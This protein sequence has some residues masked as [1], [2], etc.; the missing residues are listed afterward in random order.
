MTHVLRVAVR[1]SVKVSDRMQGCLLHLG[2]ISEA[3]QTHRWSRK[4]A[5]RRRPEGGVI[6]GQSAWD[7]GPRRA[8]GVCCLAP[9]AWSHGRE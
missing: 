6:R 2:S 4:C 7:T 8:A 3:G 9:C 5:E 1:N